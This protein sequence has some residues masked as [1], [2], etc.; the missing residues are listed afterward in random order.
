MGDAQEKGRRVSLTGYGEASKDNV[1]VLKG[2]ENVL[3]VDVD[4]LHTVYY[5]HVLRVRNKDYY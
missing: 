1:K 5:V 3:K 2:K 4:A